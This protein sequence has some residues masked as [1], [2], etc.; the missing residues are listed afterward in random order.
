MKKIIKNYAISAPLMLLATLFVINS[1]AMWPGVMS[2]DGIEQYNSALA[3]TYSDHHPPIM[4][5]I[6]HYL[7]KLHSGPGLMLS[8]HLIMLYAAAA[9]F[10]YTF[11]DSK[12][13]WWFAIYP[14]IPGV[15]AYTPLIVKDVGLAFSFLLAGSL[16]A[17]LMIGKVKKY[18]W[19]I[20]ALVVLLLFYGTAVKYQ[21]RFMVGFF[22]IGVTFCIFNYKHSWKVIISG[23]ALYLIVLQAMFSF[24]NYLVPNVQKSHSWQFVKLYDLTA[25]SIYYNKPLFPEYIINNPDFSFE[26]LKNTF[27]IYEVDSLAFGPNSVLRK[28][29]NDS[30][31]EI[32]L[33]YWRKAVIEHPFLYLKSRARLFNF[34]LTGT[35]SANTNPAQFLATIPAFKP[36]V[37]IP[38]VYSAVGKVYSIAK[39]T[40]QFT[41]LLPLLFIYCFLGFAKLGSSRSAMPLLIF[42]L[43]SLILIGILFFMSMFGTARYLFICVCLIHASHGFAY[44]CLTNNDKLSN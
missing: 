36:I 34:T 26:R 14:I 17:Y 35:P 13:K 33:Q 2:A 28:A 9:V 41:W 20:L 7:I 27:V 43:T 1:Y 18:K 31:R 15:I 21:A 30:E 25:M 22:C 42:S 12:F 29:R 23:L 3:G 6:W 24:N 40:L 8:W 11:R 16:L 4:S 39:Q 32:L 44:N 5:F 38:D 37:T 19:P 10:I